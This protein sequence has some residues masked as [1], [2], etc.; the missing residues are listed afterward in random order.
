MIFR[1]ATDGPSSSLERFQLGPNSGR[2]HWKESKGYRESLKT[3]RIIIQTC[4]EWH[5]VATPLLYEHIR[6]PNQH[7]RILRVFTGRNDK[8]LVNEQPEGDEVQEDHTTVTAI[9]SLARIPFSPILSVPLAVLYNCAAFSRN[10][11]ASLPYWKEGEEDPELLLSTLPTCLHH[12]LLVR[13]R[14]WQDVRISLASIAGFLGKHQELETLSLPFK[15]DHGPVPPAESPIGRSIRTMVF[16]NSSQAEAM[17]HLGIEPLSPNF[18]PS[19]H[20]A[21]LNHTTTRIIG[22]PLTSFQP[23]ART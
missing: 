3:K 9:S 8:E 22:A 5:T 20:F 7:N 6:I 21:W 10:S 23:M 18:A 4:R 17:A 15:I 11:V 13:R 1:S 19:T 12:L 2:L 14:D 16:Q